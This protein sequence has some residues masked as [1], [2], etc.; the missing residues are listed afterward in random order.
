MTPT[1]PTCPT[2]GAAYYERVCKHCGKPFRAFYV[3]QVFCPKPA[4]CKV[5]YF[6]KKTRDENRKRRDQNYKP[7]LSPGVLNS[8]EKLQEK[9]EG[10]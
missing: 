4:K 8:I 7:E 6:N 1:C 9:A 5:D 3:L 10:K 2:C